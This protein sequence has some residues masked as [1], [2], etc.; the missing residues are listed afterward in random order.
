[1]RLRSDAVAAG[2]SSTSKKS[3]TR[4]KSPA[5]KATQAALAKASKPPTSTASRYF[6]FVEGKS[7]KFWEITVAGTDVTVRYGRIGASGQTKTKTFADEAAAHTHADK[8][9]D[10]K[11][12]KGYTETQPS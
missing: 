11:T 8:L 12:G 6:E 4:K 9:I 2:A 1:V 3:A 5:K 7:A 10:E